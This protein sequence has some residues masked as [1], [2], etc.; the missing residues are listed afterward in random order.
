MIW[1]AREHW[2]HKSHMIQIL[3]RDSFFSPIY[4]LAII[5]IFKILNF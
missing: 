4:I 5:F 3:A 2:L 1:T